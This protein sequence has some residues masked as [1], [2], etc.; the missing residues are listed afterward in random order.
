MET[1]T[2]LSYTVNAMAADDSVTQGA[3]TSTAIVLIKFSWGILV[4]APEGLIGLSRAG[5]VYN[6]W[7]A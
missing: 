3:R 2:R 6:T 7:M 4:S 1:L 5:S